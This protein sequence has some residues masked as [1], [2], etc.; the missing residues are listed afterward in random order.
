MFTLTLNE[1]ILNLNPNYTWSQVLVL[2]PRYKRTIL[3]RYQ[4]AFVFLF[5]G[6]GDICNETNFVLAFL[7]CLDLGYWVRGVISSLL[8]F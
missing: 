5:D 7:F 8:S 3:V 6:S 1:S 2:V 4:I